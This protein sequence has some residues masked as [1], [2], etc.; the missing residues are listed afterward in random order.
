MVDI[1]RELSHI[2]KHVR[3]RVNTAGE[4]VVWFEY[5][6]EKIENGTTYDDLFDVG[7]GVE[8]EGRTYAVGV[9]IPTIYVEEMEDALVVKQE[10]RQPT[11]NVRV[12]MLYDDVKKAGL[13]QPYEYSHHI[14]DIFFYD[15]RYYK[16]SR[17][18]V[19]GRLDNDVLVT[20]TGYE[21][22]VEQEFSF[23]PG[24]EIPT[25]NALDWPTSFPGMV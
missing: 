24:P 15:G 3:H 9:T 10:A 8:G 25:I 17:Y 19:R 5:L 2:N 16:I 13:Y 1:R 6:D 22:Y 23:D 21:V 7:S 11:Q 18:E 12:V 4:H 14:N 20:A